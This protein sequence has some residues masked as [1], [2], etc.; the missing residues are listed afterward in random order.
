MSCMCYVQGVDAKLYFPS[1]ARRIPD[2]QPVSHYVLRWKNSLKNPSD[3]LINFGKFCQ[4]R[5]EGRNQ[6]FHDF[7]DL[8]KSEYT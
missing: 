2:T 5:G 8:L 6:I 4:K 3:I 7:G 1:Q